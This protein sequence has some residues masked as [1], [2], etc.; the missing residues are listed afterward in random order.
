MKR[1]RN[2]FSRIL[3]SPFL[4]TFILYL[5]FSFHFG[6]SF[7]TNVCPHHGRWCNQLCKKKKTKYHHHQQQKRWF[8]LIFIFFFSI[9]FHFFSAIQSSIYSDDQRHFNFVV[10]LFRFTFVRHSIENVIERETKKWKKKIWNIVW[11][12]RKD[13]MNLIRI[14]IHNALHKQTNILYVRV[15]PTI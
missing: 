11:I 1:K 7:W 8:L 12:Y 6:C 9:L 3:I 10:G 15:L 5:N 2:H 4:F 14:K 13:R